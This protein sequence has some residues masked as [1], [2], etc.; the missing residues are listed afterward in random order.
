MRNPVRVG[1]IDDHPMM[2]EGIAQTLKVIGGF[3]LAGLGFSREDALVLARDRRPDVMVLDVSI[4]G[5]GIEAAAQLRHLY[6]QLKIIMLTVSDR[7]DHV[8]QALQNGASGYILKGATCSELRDCLHAV[9]EGQHFVT[10]E[11]AIKLLMTKRDRKHP[12]HVETHVAPEHNFTTREL[13]VIEFLA[14]GMTN[15]EIADKLGVCE[16]TIKHYMTVVMQKLHV[17][18]RVEAV[19]LLTQKGASAHHLPHMYASRDHGD[20]NNQFDKDITE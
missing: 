17:R 9:V 3:E 8:M 1:I 15:R 13:D 14:H 11:L 10:P 5:D 6:P 19:L 2:L 16:K 12:I 18:N 4:P 7:S 20:A